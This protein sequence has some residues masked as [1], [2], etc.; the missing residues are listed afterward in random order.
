MP[1]PGSHAIAI[2]ISLALSLLDGSGDGFNANVDDETAWVLLSPLPL[3]EFEEQANGIGKREISQ[4]HLARPGKCWL[5]ANRGAVVAERT[6]SGWAPLPA[7]EQH[8]EQHA[9]ELGPPQQP[10]TA[11]EA[12][13]WWMRFTGRSTDRTVVVSNEPDLQRGPWRVVVP[14]ANSASG[15]AAHRELWMQRQD[16]AR[17]GLVYFAAPPRPPQHSG[18]GIRA[19]LQWFGALADGSAPSTAVEK[20]PPP[21]DPP[22]PRPLHTS[23]GATPLSPERTYVRLWAPR[24]KHLE[25]ESTSRD[26]NKPNRHF[27]MQRDRD[28]YHHAV[29]PL[30]PGDEYRLVLNRSRGPGI[31]AQGIPRPDPMARFLPGSVHGSARIVPSNGFPWSDSQWRGVEKR[32]LTIYELHLGAF[33]HQG[34]YRGAGERI[35]YLKSL[36]VTAVE[37]LPLAQTP[38]QWNWG[39]DGVGLYAPNNNYGSPDELKC[40]VDDCHAAGIAV[41]L[42]VVYNHL[43]PEGNYLSELGPYF[44]KKHHT[45][46][47]DAVNYDAWQSQHVR[48]WIIDNALYWLREY[49]LDGL[50]LDAVHF[51]FDDSDVTILQELRQA[52]GA[53]AE[54]QQRAIHL[55]A[56]SNMYDD[57]LLAPQTG[58]PFDAVW[59]DCL[60]HSI[61]SLGAPSVNLTYREF[62]GADDIAEALEYGYLYEGPD[63]RRVTVEEKRQRHGAESDYI[64]SLVVALQTHDSVGNH[65][66]GRRLHQLTSPEFQRAAAALVL[67]HPGIPMIF[68]GEESGAEAPFAFFADFEDP[69]LRR[70]VDRGRAKE[71]PQHEWKGAVAPSDPQAFWQAKCDVEATSDSATL[72]WYQQLLALRRQGLDEGWLDLSRLSFQRPDPHVFVL[73]YSIGSTR[74]VPSDGNDG[75]AAIAIHVCLK[76]PPQTPTCVRGEILLHSQEALGNSSPLWLGA[77]HTVICR[78]SD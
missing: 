66:H 42:D 1:H 74:S 61:Y 18:I 12:L 40:F 75:S 69:G 13:S 45:P 73:R 43:G 50:R 62:C 32:D 53:L 58:E 64:R 28:G 8:V 38:G 10:F 23:I 57:A 15:S 60:M 4:T 5:I 34:G 63:V 30:G 71:Y 26:A 7:Y 2:D 24:Q 65:P 6:G 56:E 21:T 3:S 31:I 51:M 17:R 20:A 33:S 22:A 44:A 54:E 39:Y 41:V 77:N 70:R 52:I 11:R 55:I 46:W 9:E 37:L 78:T 16:D 49:H 68:M 72:K 59:C 67:L 19:G 76:E 14:L 27:P 47:G 29:V 36:G 25:V 35:P 48:H